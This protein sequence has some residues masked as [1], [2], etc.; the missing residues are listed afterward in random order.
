MC[1]CPRIYN[2]KSI[3]KQLKSKLQIIEG[4]FE[5]RKERRSKG[6]TKDR[7][8]GRP[9]P[10]GGSLPPDTELELLRGRIADG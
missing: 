9:G 7:G 3:T 10:Q 4:S 6:S 8:E 1:H 2:N 5:V